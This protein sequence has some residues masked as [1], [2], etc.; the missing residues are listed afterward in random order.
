MNRIRLLASIAKFKKW[1]FHSQAVLKMAFFLLTVSKKNH[2]IPN[3]GMTLAGNSLPHELFMNTNISY[4]Q[5]TIQKV[6]WVTL[7]AVVFCFGTSFS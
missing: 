1:H 4:G 5:T 2:A 3:F 7:D 6:K